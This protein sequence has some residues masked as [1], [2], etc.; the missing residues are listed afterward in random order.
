MAH[1]VSSLLEF[2]NTWEFSS[3][4]RDFENSFYK[5][6]LCSNKIDFENVKLADKGEYFIIIQDFWILKR[7]FFTKVSKKLANKN[8]FSEFYHYFSAFRTYNSIQKVRFFWSWQYQNVEFWFTIW[9]F[10][11]QN[12]Q[13]YQNFFIWFDSQLKTFKFKATLI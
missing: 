4:N 3:Q 5:L 2:L 13:V 11:W 12:K 7:F 10:F 9:R 8:I 1:L 6:F